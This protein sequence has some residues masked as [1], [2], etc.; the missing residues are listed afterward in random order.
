MIDNLACH[1]FVDSEKPKAGRK[2]FLYMQNVQ[3]SLVEKK[4][5]LVDKYDDFI[6]STFSFLILVYT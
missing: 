2:W 3:L 5:S 4:H 6:I 1:K